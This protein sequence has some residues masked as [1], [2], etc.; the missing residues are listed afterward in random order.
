MKLYADTSPGLNI[1]TCY[2]EGYVVVNQARFELPLLAL[3]DRVETDW[4]PHPIDA[5]TSQDLRH[6]AACGAAIVLLGT[7]ARQRFLPP[8]LLV[9]L[10]EAGIGFEAMTT[11]AACRTY[12]ILASEGRPVAAALFSEPS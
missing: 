3:P 10:M 8:A 4:T 2:G 1:F 5:L 6:L 11:A 7:G 12:N 9:P